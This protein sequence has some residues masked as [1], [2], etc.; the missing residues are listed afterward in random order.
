V[1]D[2]SPAALAGKAATGVSFGPVT[3]PNLL[4]ALRRAVRLY[5][6]PKVWTDMQKQGMKSD[7]SWNMSAGLYAALYSDLLIRKGA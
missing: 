2:A 6:E 5:Q 3:S 7:I 1:I 4:R